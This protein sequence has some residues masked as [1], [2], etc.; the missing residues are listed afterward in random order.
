MRTC[1]EVVRKQTPWKEKDST[2]QSI[3][4]SFKAGG[5]RELKTKRPRK[6]TPILLV[7]QFPASVLFLGIAIASYCFEPWHTARRYTCRGC[8]AKLKTCGEGGTVNFNSAGAE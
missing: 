4:R 8:G 1:D 2:R 5:L 7:G 6:P 3:N